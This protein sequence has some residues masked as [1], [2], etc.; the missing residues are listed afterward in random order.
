MGIN[1]RIACSSEKARERDLGCALEKLDGNVAYK[2]CY[3]WL[4]TDQRSMPFLKDW[5]E[6]VPTVLGQKEVVYFNSEALTVFILNGFTKI[7]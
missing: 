6:N 7:K 4:K 1:F 5:L 2:V 3:D